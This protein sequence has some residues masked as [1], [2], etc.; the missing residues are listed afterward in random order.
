MKI[1]SKIKGGNI[2]CNEACCPFADYCANFGEQQ[3]E[4]DEFPGYAPEIYEENKVVFCESI[5]NGLGS[6]P[7]KFYLDQSGNLMIKTYSDKDFV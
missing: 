7:G 4:D 1:N 3:Y 6:Y 2:I 5:E